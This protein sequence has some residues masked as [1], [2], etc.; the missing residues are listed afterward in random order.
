M[1]HLWWLHWG[2][3]WCPEDLS[4][5]SFYLV[6]IN[7]WFSLFCV[8]GVAIQNLTHIYN[9]ECDWGIGFWKY[10]SDLHK[11]NGKTPVAPPNAGVPNPQALTQYWAA[12]PLEPG[13]RSGGWVRA[14]ALLDLREQQVSMRAT[15]W[16]ARMEGEHARSYI[17]ASGGHTCFVC[18]PLSLPPPTRKAGKVLELCPNVLSVWP[19]SSKIWPAAWSAIT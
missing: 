1:G 12:A 11:K 15:A 6:E 16:L 14:H 8:S 4:C 17:C 3:P 2:S 13:R 7:G 10:S 5:C 18:N 9:R 19:K